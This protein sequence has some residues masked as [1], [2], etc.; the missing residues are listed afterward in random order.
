MNTDPSNKAKTPEESQSLKLGTRV[1]RKRR[2]FTLI[3][4]KMSFLPSSQSLAQIMDTNHALELIISNHV[5]A[6]RLISVS[7]SHDR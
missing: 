5:A 6:L 2:S 1:R 4:W 3:E 7:G